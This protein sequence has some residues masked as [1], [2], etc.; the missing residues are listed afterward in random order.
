MELIRSE[1]AALLD[2]AMSEADELIEFLARIESRLAAD[3]QAI[4]AGASRHQQAIIEKLRK[5][6]RDHDDLPA[7]GDPE[8]GELRAVATAVHA[9]FS[10]L[11]ETG[12]NDTIVTNAIVDATASSRESFAQIPQ[13]ELTETQRS[14]VAEYCD[15][16]STLAARLRDAAN[17]A[18]R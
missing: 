8:R 1:S 14:L 10:S 6:R 11:L 17:Q 16:C 2:A 7:V 3:E 9:I 18:T 15:S 12:D 4:V 13:D 5:D